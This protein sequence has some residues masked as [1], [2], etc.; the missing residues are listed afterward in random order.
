MTTCS[1]CGYANTSPG[2]KCAGCGAL[3]QNAGVPGKEA[4]LGML[5]VLGALVFVLGYG[6]FIGVVAHHSAVAQAAEKTEAERVK[7]DDVR[8]VRLEEQR[9]QTLAEQARL[10]GLEKA[11]IVRSPMEYSALLAAGNPV[12]VAAKEDPALGD[13]FFGG[14]EG[15]TDASYCRANRPQCSALGTDL[16]T[17]RAEQVRLN[18]QAMELSGET[19]Y[20][21][22][23]ENPCGAPVR[24]KVVTDDVLRGELGEVM[25]LKSQESAVPSPDNVR[26]RS[27]D[28]KVRYTMLW[29]SGQSSLSS[30]KTQPVEAQGKLNGAME[31]AVD[32]PCHG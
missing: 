10:V 25:D 24:V 20:R 31:W 6:V 16:Q 26:M 15:L 27:R 3:L 12:A 19:G 9:Q 22:R 1:E 32:L 5:A 21:V 29:I 4:R 28:G 7:R 17:L 11:R 8:L 18:G 2:D 30:A 14:L 23:V 13:G